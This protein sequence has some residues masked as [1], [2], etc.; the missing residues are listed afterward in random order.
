MIVQINPIE[1]KGAPRTAR[2]ILNRMNEITFNGSL[3]KELR[4]IDFVRRLIDE[5]KIDGRQYKQLRVHIVEAQAQLRPLGASS[6]LNAEWAFLRHLF[7]IGR[8]AADEWLSLNYEDI[9][10]QS[11]VDL[12]AMFQGIGAIHHG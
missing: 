1:R 10:Q 2:E 6:K 4:S 9:G 8:T 7:E 11:T 12:R 3:L 5:G